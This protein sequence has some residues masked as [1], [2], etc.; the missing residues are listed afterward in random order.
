[1]AAFSRTGRRTAGQADA[2]VQSGREAAGRGNLGRFPQ[3]L[4]GKKE[5][6]TPCCHP[7]VGDAGARSEL[8]QG[9]GDEER[10][11]GWPAAGYLPPGRSTKGFGSHQGVGLPESS[12]R[13][14]AVGWGQEEG[15]TP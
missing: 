10:D 5:D 1:M 11:R 8:R 7:H 9:Q 3:E 12:Q 13:T 6:K 15:P 4:R 2:T 14:R